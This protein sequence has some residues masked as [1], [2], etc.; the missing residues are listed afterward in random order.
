MKQ[1]QF[2]FPRSINGQEFVTESEH[3]SN[4]EDQ[5]NQNKEV[6][7]D[8]YWC[9]VSEEKKLKVDFSFATNA[10]KKALDLSANL[11]LLNPENVQVSLSDEIWSVT[12]S[13][14]KIK[15]QLDDVTNWTVQM[16]ELGYQHDCEF[17]GW[18]AAIPK[19]PPTKI[20]QGLTFEKYFEMANKHFY[21]G[22]LIKAE[23]FFTK[24][25]E[26][27]PNDIRSHFNRGYV[28]SMRG[29]KLGAI[30]DYTKA[31]ELDPQCENAY[32]NRGI[33]RDHTGDYEGALADFTNAIKLNP[34]S[35][36]AYFNRGITYEN[37]GEIENACKDWKKA[38]KLGDMTA[39]NKLDQYC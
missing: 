36:L 7:L 10:E 22:K 12:G 21:D 24:A 19:D 4:I 2:N 14:G 15:M 13:C 34:K 33:E 35:E 20:P 5:S 18:G 9:G 8:I 3:K 32:G 30:L 29:N 1:L 11:K 31:I 27:K 26:M 38:K 25:L 16:C 6:L 28:K 37:L 39:Q 23:A 17:E